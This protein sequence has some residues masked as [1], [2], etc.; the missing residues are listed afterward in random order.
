[1]TAPLIDLGTSGAKRAA[2]TSAKDFDLCDLRI[3]AVVVE[4]TVQL[5]FLADGWEG[6]PRQVLS[7]VFCDDQTA[8]QLRAI[9]D[10][11]DQVFAGPL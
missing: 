3:V 6:G 5:A 4:G 10:Y 11:L 8:G 9:A 7:N 1:M 2:V